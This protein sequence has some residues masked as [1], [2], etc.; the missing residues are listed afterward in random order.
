MNINTNVYK[1]YVKSGSSRHCTNLHYTATEKTVAVGKTD[2]FSLSSE[3][4]MFRECGKVIRNSIN[5]ITASASEDRI[6]SLRQQIKDGT[7]NVSS[8]QIASAILE[9]IV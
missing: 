1:Q 8:D 2:S 4:S 7:Y 3:A 5:E 6:N 9:R